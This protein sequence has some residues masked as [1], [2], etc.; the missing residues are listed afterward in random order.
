MH[1]L[2]RIVTADKRRDAH[3]AQVPNPFRDSQRLL[4][5]AAI[6]ALNT[7]PPPAHQFARQLPAAATL[8]H[9]W[10]A[11]VAR[12]ELATLQHKIR[13][14]CAELHREPEVIGDIWVKR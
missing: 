10:H 13:A 6:I 12:K 5:R 2:S 8:T 11:C 1:A 7:I 4:G 3:R 14:R 9:A